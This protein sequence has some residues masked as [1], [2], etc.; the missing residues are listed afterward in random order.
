MTSF[1]TKWRAGVDL[2]SSIHSVNSMSTVVT[3]CL[4][5][6]FCSIPSIKWDLSWPC[7]QKR[8]LIEFCI[9]WSMIAYQ[10]FI[11]FRFCL[12]CSVLSY[13]SFEDSFSNADCIAYNSRRVS[14]WSGMWGPSWYKL[15]YPTTLLLAALGPTQPPVRWIL[16]P[17][18]RHKAAGAW[19]WPPAPI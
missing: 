6:G 8:I 18:P 11:T 7:E 14:E 3:V 16:G 17:F 12:L 2:L 1:R 10:R 13:T 4:S 5:K 15:K 9:R 19:R